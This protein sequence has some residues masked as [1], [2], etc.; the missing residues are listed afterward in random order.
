M[1]TRLDH[2]GKSVIVIRDDLLGDGFICLVAGKLLRKY[3]RP[4]VV[5]TEG[6]DGALKGSARRP[7]GFNL[8][9][10]LEVVRDLTI[11]MGGHS[12][13]RSINSN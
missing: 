13:C 3:N 11:K 5:F 7:E 4:S 8:I 9:E 12:S 10:N 2:T 1:R 6:H